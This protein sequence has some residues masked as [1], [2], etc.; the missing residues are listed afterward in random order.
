MKKYFTSLDIEKI[1][2]EYERELAAELDRV[3][4]ED[5]PEDLPEPPEPSIENILAGAVKKRIKILKN[6]EHYEAKLMQLFRLTVLLEDEEYPL[7]EETRESCL[8]Y[9][10]HELGHDLLDI[11]QVLDML[12]DLGREKKPS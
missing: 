2:S 11:L 8:E 9:L 5:Y 10:L 1:L 7:D 3:N 6:K 4:S 12:P